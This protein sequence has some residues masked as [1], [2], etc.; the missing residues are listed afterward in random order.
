MRI[1]F[2]VKNQ[3]WQAIQAGSEKA[4]DGS[5]FFSVFRLLFYLRVTVPSPSIWLDYFCLSSPCLMN[6]N[7]TVCFRIILYEPLHCIFAQKRIKKFKMKFIIVVSA[8]RKIP[9]LLQKINISNFAW[10]VKR[11]R[12]QQIHRKKLAKPLT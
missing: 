9:S 12:I 5:E 6:I 10:L 2:C 4:K 3:I 1:Q 7:S 8:F 11:P